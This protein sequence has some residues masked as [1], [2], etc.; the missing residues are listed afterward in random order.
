MAVQSRVTLESSPLDVAEATSSSPFI[1]EFETAQARKVLEDLQSGN[2]GRLPV[3]EEWVSVPSPV[4]DPQVS[5]VFAERTRETIR[6]TGNRIRVR[7][8]APVSALTPQEAQIARQAAIGATNREIAAAMFISRHTVDYHLRSVFRKIG[9]SSRRELTRVVE[10][11]ASLIP[12]RPQ[13]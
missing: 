13:S 11:E 6:R 7:A 3:D 9:I 1:R 2:V 12:G 8:A 5:Q 4:G 10:V